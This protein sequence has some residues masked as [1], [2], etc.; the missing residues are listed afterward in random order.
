MS[1]A[2]TPPTIDGRLEDPA[3]QTA[4]FFQ[5]LTQVEPV[6]GAPAS[7]DTIIK[8]LYDRD[9]LY[10]GVRCFDHEPDKILA[11]QMVRDSLMYSDDNFSIMLDT[12]FDER[13]AYHFA[14]NPLGNKVDGLIEDGA[15][16][17]EWDGIWYART[18]VD[19]QGWVAEI[20]I[21]FKTVTFDPKG[22][23]W[24]FNFAREIRR[25]NEMARL[26][27]A[28]LSRDNA[29]MRG[30]AILEGL[31][32]ME[33]GLGL[34]AKPSISVRHRRYREEQRSTSKGDPALDIFYKIT[35]SLTGA[36]T[37][38]TDFADAEVDERQINLTRF[39][40]FFPE[41]RDFFL[42]DAGIFD[43]AG[44]EE[45][46]ALP[47]FSRR[48][49]IAPDGE[50]IDIDAGAKLTG[51]IG[52]LNV[53]LLNVQMDEYHEIERTNLSVGRVKF[54]VF[55]ESTFGVIATHGHPVANEDN[56]LI[57]SDFN[58]QNTQLFGD[59]KLTGNIWVQKT[60]S[61]GS[62]DHEA[63]FGAKLDYP[64]DRINFTLEAEE[65]QENYNPALGFVNRVDIRRYG[66]AFRYRI[67]PEGYL[68]TVDFGFD[69]TL[70]TSV[71]NHLESSRLSLNL[72]EFANQ[73][74]DTLGF[75]FI[76]DEE[77]LTEAFEISEGVV[78]SIG[79]YRFDHGRVEFETT[80]IRPVN[81]KIYLDWGQFYSGRR[82]ETSTGVEWRPSPHVFL[83]LE[84]DQNDVRLDEGDFTTRLARGRVNF[85]FTPDLSWNTF[86]QYDNV[87]DL[88]SINSRIR[89]IVEPGNE[90]FLVLNHA[91][92]VDGADLRT[93]RSE[94]TSKIV[95][96]FRF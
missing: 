96:T 2:E 84:Y 44:R 11:S 57:G 59:Q 49:G 26:A 90:I 76:A 54:N 35:P 83:S 58:Y 7:E 19:D 80:D 12:F 45:V 61:E 67:R 85:I 13:N 37:L 79:D 30:V 8:L 81:V 94:L 22:T 41:Q 55:E 60:F 33:Q 42:Q 62:H 88:F 28:D 93:L 75:K 16:R 43:F 95:W 20:A 36:L 1:R 24:G 40:L 6:E 86:L 3:W 5:G 89:W 46:N 47:F 65:I 21:P 27:A 70:V 63:A 25:K 64:N 51:R 52:R 69:G 56:A 77:R 82:F 39:P 48:I 50:E 38:N 10:L 71:S 53:G 31:R 92:H 9:Y 32:D 15:W 87:S 17:G 74:G 66:A 73:L 18:S 4:P 78:I 72:V 14:L 34:D 68:H 23:R 91:Y 29:D